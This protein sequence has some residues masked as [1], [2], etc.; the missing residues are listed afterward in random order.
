MWLC[1]CTDD[2]HAEI[3]KNL[4]SYDILNFED[5]FYLFLDLKHSKLMVAF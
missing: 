5:I 4:I 3:T 2:E 1:D